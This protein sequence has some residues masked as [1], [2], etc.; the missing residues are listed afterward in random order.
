V[1]NSTQEIMI[2]HPV[3]RLKEKV[4]SE[5]NI[6][7]YIDPKNIKA[8]NETLQKTSALKEKEID[9]III[10]LFSLW[11]KLKNNNKNRN[12]CS[13][14][15]YIYLNRLDD[16]SL[17]FSMAIIRKFTQSLKEFLED[18]DLDKNAHRIII[19]A[20]LDVINLSHESKIQDIN[21]RDAKELQTILGVAMKKNR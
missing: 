3:N 2:I 14:L 6:D 20:H 19:Q 15:F 21:S 12:H 18:Y 11:D 4:G 1:L 16:L 5:K 17:L 10:N 7:I 13:T 9:H 8:A